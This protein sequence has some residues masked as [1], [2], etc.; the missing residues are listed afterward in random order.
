[1]SK[2]FWRGTELI[3]QTAKKTRIIANFV[4]GTRAL[5]TGTP[6]G[7]AFLVGAGFSVP[8]RKG[9]SAPYALVYRRTLDGA[10]FLIHFVPATGETAAQRDGSKGWLRTTKETT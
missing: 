5:Q 1:M 6:Y 10:S 9:S 2:L 3:Y 7:G 4:S 8:L